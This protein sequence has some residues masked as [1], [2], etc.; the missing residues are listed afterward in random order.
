MTVDQEQALVS[1]V[2]IGTLPGRALVV[3]V[4]DEVE[5]AAREQQR[6]DA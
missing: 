2:D 4:S 1:G 5:S 6:V 3:R